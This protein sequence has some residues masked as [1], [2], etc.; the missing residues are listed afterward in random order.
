[1]RFAWDERKNAENLRKHDISFEQAQKIFEDDMGI[2]IPDPDHSIGEER[3][4]LIGAEIG[5]GV[6]IVCHCYIDRGE[7]IRLISARPASKQEK[8]QYRRQYEG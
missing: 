8:E 6:C 7:I 1:M 3:Y 2:L 4:V 5:L